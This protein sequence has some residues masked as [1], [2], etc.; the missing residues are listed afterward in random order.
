VTHVENAIGF[1][2]NHGWFV[3]MVF[4][5]E[6]RDFLYIFPS[7][8]PILAFGESESTETTQLAGT[9]TVLPHWHG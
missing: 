3:Y 9:V 6:S 1:R 7:T 2:E 4:T 8:N 5:I